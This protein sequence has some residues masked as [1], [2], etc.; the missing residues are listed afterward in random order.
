MCPPLWWKGASRRS[1]RS[2]ANSRAF[3]FS[4]MSFCELRLRNEPKEP[5]VFQRFKLRSLVVGD[6]DDMPG[7]KNLASG[8][9]GTLVFAAE[10][11]PRRRVVLA[12]K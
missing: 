12:G 5:K 11:E 1:S 2:C 7:T 6:L 8:A 9:D 4:A 3:F 10:P